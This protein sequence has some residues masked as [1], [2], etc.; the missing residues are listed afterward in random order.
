M[1]VIETLKFIKVANK[2]KE[3]DPNPWAVCEKSVGK[4]KDPS[5]FERCVKDVKKDQKEAQF[6]G[7]VFTPELEDQYTDRREQLYR[8]RRNLEDINEKRKG[9]SLKEKRRGRDSVNKNMN[10]QEW[11]DFL[12]SKL[13]EPILSSYKKDTKPTK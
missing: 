11:R 1:K 5:K 10:D 6:E 7:Q 9:L 12:K 4:K 3:W 2:K 8:K 13:R